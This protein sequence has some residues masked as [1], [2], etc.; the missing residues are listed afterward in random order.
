MK[1][2]IFIL[3]IQGLSYK[4]LLH[5]LPYFS[6]V[7]G[8]AG[9]SLRL[10]RLSSGVPGCPEYTECQIT[11]AVIWMTFGKKVVVK[12]WLLPCLQR[13]SWSYL[14]GRLSICSPPGGGTRAKTYM[15][16]LC[17]QEITTIQSKALQGWPRSGWPWAVLL[18]CQASLSLSVTVEF[19]LDIVLASWN[20]KPKISDT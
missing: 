11:L 5:M 18:S 3:V 1:H 10:S 19:G 6:V 12:C 7:L 8:L 17:A 9:L 13:T 15:Q 14:G 20:R 16:R 4:S 2:T